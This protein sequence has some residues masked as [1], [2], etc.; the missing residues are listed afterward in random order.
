VIGMTTAR[1][2]FKER[3]THKAPM[4]VVRVTTESTSSPKG[5][6][7]K[8]AAVIART[9]A[10]KRVPPKSLRSAVRTLT[11]FI[12]RA[13]TGLTAH[14]RR[15]LEKA[16]RLISARLAKSRQMKQAA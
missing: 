12:D 14:R 7:K 10:S 1:K 6:F 5:L 13:G 8:S 16:R 2:K 15:E 4:K 11:R 9:L 3:A